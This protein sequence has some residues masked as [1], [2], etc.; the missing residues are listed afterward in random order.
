VPQAAEHPAF[1]AFVALGSASA[2]L[3]TALY[4]DASIFR[5]PSRPARQRSI[6]AMHAGVT[7]P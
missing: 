5:P 6:H 3:G 7:R 1:A 4:D 2:R